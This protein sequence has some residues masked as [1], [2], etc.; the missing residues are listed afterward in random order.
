MV[1]SERVPYEAQVSRRSFLSWSAA[2]ALA[3]GGGL[4]G[5]AP[6]KV[7]DTGE[8]G[9]AVEEDSGEWV[10]SPC[11]NSGSCLQ[12]CLN[13]SLIKDGVIVRHRAQQAMTA[14][15]IPCAWGVS[16]A[17]CSGRWCM[18]RAA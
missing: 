7:A 1:A 3:T 17:V 12:N 8:I 11:W 9:A 2:A 5:C 18:A 14:S 13:Q 4:I 16:R 6:T 15:R 10:G